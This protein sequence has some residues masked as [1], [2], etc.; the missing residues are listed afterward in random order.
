LFANFMILEEA[1]TA[2]SDSTLVAVSGNRNAFVN[3]HINGM[4]TAVGAARAGSY[5]L[6]LN[7]AQENSF[8]GCTIGADTV[9]RTAA[10]ASVI[11]RNQAARNV[12]QDCLFPMWTDGVA[13]FID[14]GAV[15]ALDR[16]LLMKNA[17]LSNFIG[18]TTCAAALKTDANTGGCVIMDTCTLV[19]VTQYSA[20]NPDVVVKVSGPVPNGF[21]SGKAL[22]SATS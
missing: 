8:L 1:N 2:S 9:R 14:V 13:F 4:T 7:G 21:S 5:A 3:V 12:F 17:T 19:F 10:N 18:G 22:S 16:W 15:S 20:T 11:C 6:Y